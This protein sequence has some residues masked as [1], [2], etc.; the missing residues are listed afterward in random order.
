MVAV[1]DIET[2]GLKFFSEPVQIQ[3]SLELES[4]FST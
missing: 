4:I 3:Q 1:F 2:L